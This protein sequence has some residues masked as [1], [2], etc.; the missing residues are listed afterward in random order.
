MF[1]RAGE[2]IFN[3]RERS[4]AV[5]PGSYSRNASYLVP[6]TA[7]TLRT[8]AEVA[9]HHTSDE[10]KPDPERRTAMIPVF[11]R[12]LPLVRL[13]DGS[14]DGQSHAHPFGLAGEERF[15]NFSYFAF[16][17]ARAAIRHG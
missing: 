13:D 6:L 14:R 5:R 3:S 8:S 1:A 17:N 9:D 11:C 16:R 7:A 12:Y 4:E 10:R 15:E 2:V